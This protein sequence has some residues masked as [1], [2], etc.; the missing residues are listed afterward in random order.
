MS[1]NDVARGRP[2]SDE[3]TTSV[4]AAV[5]AA[6]E[7]SDIRSVSRSQIAVAAGVSRQTLYN[8]W[9][10][11]GDILLDALL[12]RAQ[13]EITLREPALTS[14]L[15]TYLQDL[16][17]AVNGWAKNGLRCIAGLAQ[18]DRRF[19]KRFRTVLIN[20]RH[21]RLTQAVAA[22]L[23]DQSVDVEFV[24]E[25][26]AGSMWYRLLVTQQSL[27]NEWS[28]RIITTLGLD[29]QT[30]PPPAIRHSLSHR[31]GSQLARDEWG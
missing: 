10:S 2:L 14:T 31:A 20:P 6:A 22:S 8:R 27:D 26:I 25:L 23:S 7:G 13:R 28:K 16:T 15:E 29:E 17:A 19:A 24:A 18:T 11:V 4:F 30:A 5:V 3:V 21:Q 1:T 12:D 9:D